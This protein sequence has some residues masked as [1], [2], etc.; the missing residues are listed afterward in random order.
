LIDADPI[1]RLFREVTRLA[2]YVR[3]TTRLSASAS[4]QEV[5]LRQLAE[6]LGHRVVRVFRDGS[7][8][9]SGSRESRKAL[10]ALAMGI[11]SRRID[12]V[13]VWSLPVVAGSPSALGT[14]LVGLRDAGVRLLVHDADPQQ[15]VAAGEA[16]LAAGSHLADLGRS[17]R[18]RRTLAGQAH[19]VARGKH[20]GRP[21][22]PDERVEKVHA[23]LAEGA[24]IRAAARIAGVSPASALRI[25]RSV[26]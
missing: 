26:R 21:R 19:A 16:L 7:P 25:A 4:A 12:M 23:A 10:S 2:I 11:Q 20:I 17:D 14:F 3:D 5:D 24:G 22:V 13:A 1:L 9:R 6:T 15:A 18:R 8:P